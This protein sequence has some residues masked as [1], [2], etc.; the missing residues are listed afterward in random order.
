MLASASV[1]WISEGNK[2]MDFASDLHFLRSRWSM[3]EQAS[4]TGDWK[5]RVDIVRHSYEWR[6]ASSLFGRASEAS[7]LYGEL[8]WRLRKVETQPDFAR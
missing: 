8:C 6:K 2:P 5:I 7:E 3:E 1:E 4:A